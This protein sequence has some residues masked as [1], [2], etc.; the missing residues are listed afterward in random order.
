MQEDVFKIPIFDFKDIISPEDYLTLVSYKPL[1]GDGLTLELIFKAIKDN[2]YNNSFIIEEYLRI[3]KA[4]K[5]E[6]IFELIIEC[7]T[8]SLDTEFIINALKA[9]STIPSDIR[10]VEEPVLKLMNLIK[11]AKSGVIIYYSAALLYKISC[12]YPSILEFLKDEKII[13]KENLY[14]SLFDT[15]NKYEHIDLQFM[16]SSKLRREVFNTEKFIKFCKMII[17]CEYA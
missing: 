8:I 6:D 17:E 10:K 14:K 3:L 16:A 11:N 15:I 13:M 4:V 9:V 7:A 5:C 1:I 12:I 2:H